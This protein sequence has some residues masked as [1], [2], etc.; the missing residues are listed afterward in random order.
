MEL[1][2]SSR[3]LAACSVRPERSALP[4]AISEDADE[5]DVVE[6][7]LSSSTYVDD[8]ARQQAIANAKSIEESAHQRAKGGQA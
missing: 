2:V 8:A 3:L 1:A 6:Q 5:I 4:L 7:Q